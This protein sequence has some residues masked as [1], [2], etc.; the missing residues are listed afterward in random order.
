[1]SEI[2]TSSTSKLPAADVTVSASYTS[3]SLMYGQHKDSQADLLQIKSSP[4]PHSAPPQMFSLLGT[5]QRLASG[6]QTTTLSN[7]GSLG[8]R[9]FTILNASSKSAY[10]CETSSGLPV[11]AS[12]LQLCTS[13]LST[14]GRAFTGQ[15]SLP[16]ISSSPALSAFL[17]DKVTGKVW[18]ND[19]AKQ[20]KFLSQGMFLPATIA[21][22]SGGYLDIGAVEPEVEEEELGHAETYA[23]YKPAKL[24][25]GCGHPDPAVES[26]SLSSVEPP[27][28][29]Y[30]LNLPKE[31][32]LEGRLSS[33]QLETITY[34]CQKHE[35]FLPNKQRVGYLVGDGA[36]VGKGRTIAGIIFENFR[37]GRKRALWL[38]VSNDLLEDARRDL[39]D[40][41]AHDIELHAL[42]K[43]KYAK[44]SSKIN[45][46]VKR[47]VIF[48]TYSSLIGES[49]KQ[50][51]Y[52]TRMKQVL[53]WLGKE[54]E[55]LIIFDECHRAKN[56]IPNGSSKATKTGLK[57]VELQ[58]SL[59]N[60]R[61][62]Y[63][64]A[65]GASEPKNMA[66]MVR[67]GLW[68]TGTPFKDFSEFH[69]A[70]KKRGVGAMELVAMEMKQRGTYIARQLSFQ[71][72]S[73]KI[74]EVHI[75][76]RFV[77]L[78]NEC[79]RLWV[80]T[81]EYFHEALELLNNDQAKYNKTAWGQYWSTHQRFFK[82]ICISTKVAYAVELS[83]EAVEKGKSVVIGLQS[84]GEAKTLEQLESRGWE[85]TE[86]V[87]T[88]KGVFQKLIESH[89]PNP[90][91][92][93]TWSG[94][95]EMSSQ[96]LRTKEERGKR[97][98]TSFYQRNSKRLKLDADC[99]ESNS[100]KSSESDSTEEEEIDSLETSEVDGNEEDEEEE[101]VERDWESESDDDTN[102]FAK[103]SGSDDDSDPWIRKPKKRFRELE[104]KKSEKKSDKKLEKKTKKKRSK[105][106]S[107]DEE[108]GDDFEEQAAK[109]VTSLSQKEV[110]GSQLK[111]MSH[112][113]YPD[114]M[115]TRDR[116]AA[117]KRE[118][119]DDIEELGPRLPSNTLD[120]L[121]EKLGGKDAV[122]EMTG[123]KGRMVMTASGIIQYESRGEVDATLENINN[124]ERQRF[125]EGVKRIA[126]ISEAASS[127]ISLHADR[128]SRNQTRRVHITLE[129]PW[130][131]DRAIQQFGRTHRSNQVNSPEYIFLISELAGERRFA[132]TVAKR[133]ESL[134]AL[135]HGDRR[136]TETRDLSQFNID[137]RYGQ[138]ALSIVIKFVLS[139]ENPLVKVPDDYK[140]D[141]CGDVQK[142]LAGVGMGGD[143][144]TGSRDKEQNQISKF[145][146]RIL[147]MEVA[148]QNA[149]FQYFTSTLEEVVMT[150]RREGTWD[151]GILDIGSSGEHVLEK[152]TREFSGL[153]SGF[154][155]KIRLTTVIVERGVNWSL[156]VKM[157]DENT[158]EGSG[159][160]SNKQQQVS[161]C[162]LFNL[163]KLFAPIISLLPL[164]FLFCGI[165]NPLLTAP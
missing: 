28:I 22:Q 124:T 41:G 17:V 150:A 154:Q 85:L 84:T 67:L 3:T 81:R 160:Y 38:S 142:A 24:S 146:N 69:S 89:F 11:S 18:V 115:S 52:S 76:D 13:K 165:F 113:S 125:M 25:I 19:I 148:V 86:F 98:M 48:A 75:S 65:T 74:V 46:K 68:G 112:K 20:G 132:A 10:N 23:D 9:N 128:R 119:L 61:I 110:I 51:K 111:S 162:L 7:V 54:F 139:K 29:E 42:N 157:L 138:Q 127:G 152:E 151:L 39:N 80:K 94:S 53:R 90:D 114:N 136:A 92:S 66:Y 145:L 135:T 8:V 82:Y 101:G 109:A 100:R 1:M 73:F 15:M 106:N 117:M 133:L 60:A 27:D 129:L 37:C 14:G 104:P 49:Q 62:V 87:S 59:P 147:G 32:I 143:F 16:S 99:S 144:N 5:H 123:R 50:G 4:S 36:G 35:T 102:P 163:C 149:L 63:A 40:V 55:C 120:E 79:V 72:V 64:S 137:N 156:A 134:G 44:I 83:L 95:D 26:S 159:F 56:L 70:I 78:Y 155:T 161:A 91:N 88:A 103:A 141:F 21:Q 118:L 97:K 2:V 164:C 45:Q 93:D 30:S 158:V 43:F 107:S 130:S 108:F 140:G 47:G 71:G 77:K 131:A 153:F 126:I 31:V 12:S 96:P 58:D 34:A 121:I 105:L 122:A 33:L 6:V 116:I 57:V